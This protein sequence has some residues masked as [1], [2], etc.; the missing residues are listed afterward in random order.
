MVYLKRGIDRL[1]VICVDY[2]TFLCKIVSLEKLL[3]QKAIKQL[4]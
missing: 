4:Y 2:V 1:P 3:I